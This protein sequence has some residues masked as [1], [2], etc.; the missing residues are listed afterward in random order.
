MPSL[1]ALGADGIQLITDMLQLDPCRRLSAI[2]ALKSTF[3]DEVRDIY[4]DPVTG[5]LTGAGAAAAIAKGTTGGQKS[6]L[7]K[8]NDMFMHN[9]VNLD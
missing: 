7:N 9:D 6:T 1:E 4:V 3:F 5:E 2:D 8:E